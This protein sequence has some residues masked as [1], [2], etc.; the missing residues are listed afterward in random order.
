[1]IEPRSAT[2]K[3]P[4]GCTLRRCGARRARSVTTSRTGQTQLGASKSA[5]QQ[6]C[7]QCGAGYIY[8]SPRH[9]SNG[10]HR[11]RWRRSTC[12]SSAPNAAAAR[13]LQGRSPETSV[14]AVYAGACGYYCRLREPKVVV[15]V[16]ARA[17]DGKV[18]LAKRAIEQ[19]LGTWGIPRRFMELRRN[20]AGSGRAGSVRG[21]G[22]RP[23]SVGDGPARSL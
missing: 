6:P 17:P 2:L 16:V 12:R 4:L 18:L 5:H 23:Q 20:D 14:R 3:Q 15:A 7:S 22:R 10:P 9:C 8:S 11:S 19:R 1:M 21:D 13:W